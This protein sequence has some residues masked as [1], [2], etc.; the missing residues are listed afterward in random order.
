MFKQKAQN[1][2]NDRKQVLDVKLRSKQVKNLRMRMAAIAL[3]ICAGCILGV[4]LLWQGGELLLRELVYA[5]PSFAVQQIHIAS[6]GVLKP[7]QLAQWAG[8]EKGQNLLTL[9]LTQIKRNLELVPLVKSVSIEK[10]L[11]NNLRIQV[12]EREP[13]AQVCLFRPAGPNVPVQYLNYYIDE[14]GVVIPPWSEQPLNDEESYPLPVLTGLAATELRP[15]VPVENGSVKAALAL[16]A[17]FNRSPLL[18]MVELRSIDTASP[19]TLL[20]QTD[21]RSEI[22]FAQENFEEQFLRW[23]SVLEFASNQQKVIATL[24]LAVGNYVPARWSEAPL[25][26]PTKIRTP[27]PPFKKR[28][29]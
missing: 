28:H 19:H 26:P 21:Q 12:T 24:D 1:R 2:R 3:T 8:V 6:D 14:D 13:I 18:G 10:I 5:N 4:F 9:D 29:V 11:P 15:G 27:K 17:A 16:I 23:L 7:A 25:I 22:V 20:V